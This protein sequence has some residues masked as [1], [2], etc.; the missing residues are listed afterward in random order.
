MVASDSDVAGKRMVEDDNEDHGE[1]NPQDLSSRAK[2][3][4]TAYRLLSYFLG[5]GMKGAVAGV[6]AQR[7]LSIHLS[8]ADTGTPPV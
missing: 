3:E 6:A 1:P 2:R 8:D 7:A 5:Q 4:L